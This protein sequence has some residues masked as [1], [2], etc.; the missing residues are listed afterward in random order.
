[1]LQRT[2]AVGV[3]SDE[4]AVLF[5][6]S[7]LRNH[8]ASAMD[9]AKACWEWSLDLVLQVLICLLGMESSKSFRVVVEAHS[10]L[11][12]FEKRC[13]FYAQFYTGSPTLSL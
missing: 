11:A 2:E 8:G 13:F 1:V 7:E 9:I 3:V 12:H 4:G 5:L 6:S 10:L